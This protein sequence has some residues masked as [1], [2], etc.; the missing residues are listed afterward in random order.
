M[1]N[2][3]LLFISSL[4][5]VAPLTSCGGNE[6][7]YRPSGDDNKVLKV[8]L[9]VDSMKLTEGQTLQLHP[10]IT[11]KDD[12]EV[13]VYTEWRSSKTNVALVSQDG[14]VTAISSGKTTITFMAGLKGSASCEITVL[15]E[16]PI[17]PTPQ[18]GEFSIYLNQTSLIQF[19][20]DGS[21]NTFCIQTTFLQ[22]EFIC[23]SM[24]ESMNTQGQ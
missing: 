6:L 5:L 11:Y 3:K 16:T 1:K 23:F 14:L 10:T 13:E 20:P 24:L 9:D 12:V 19:G 15:G 7:P 18:P 8:E 4:L 21:S 22:H 17:P 2:F